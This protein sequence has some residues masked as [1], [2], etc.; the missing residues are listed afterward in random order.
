L[1]E[2]TT[3]QNFLEAD[4]YGVAKARQEDLLLHGDRRNWTIVRPYISYDAYRLQLGILEKEEW[5]ARVMRGVPIIF[6]RQLLGRRTTMTWG[7]DV[8]SCL[9]G[10]VGLTAA[11]GQA[12]NITTAES[13][14]WSEV[15]E[16][17]EQLIWQRTGQRA[18]VHLCELHDFEGAFPRHYQIHYDRLFDRVFDNGKIAQIVDVTRFKSLADGLT[19]AMQAFFQ[20]PRF[21]YIDWGAEGRADR[22]AGSWALPRGAPTARAALKYLRYRWIPCPRGAA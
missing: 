12:F 1:L 6:P 4:E 3:D 17:Y 9:V 19:V 16:Q 8:A 22:V 21:G 10:L 18:R 11:C 13:H 20:Q 15:L 2:E 5:L 7:R 14:T